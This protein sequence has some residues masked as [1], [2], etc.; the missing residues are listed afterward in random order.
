MN[1]AAGVA[2]NV[3]GTS[4]SWRE[5]AVVAA[6]LSSR[7]PYAPSVSLLVSAGITNS[8]ITTHAPGVIQRSE[9][10]HAISAFAALSPDR[11]SRK[12]LEIPHCVQD[13]KQGALSRHSRSSS[14]GKK[15][16]RTK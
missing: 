3:A 2:R 10:S 13:D 8:H 16:M 14:H 12:K 11:V 1:R 9:G 4:F 6:R 7:N 15:S 5:N